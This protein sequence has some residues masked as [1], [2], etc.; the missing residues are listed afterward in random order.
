MEYLNVKLIK[1]I[2]D[3]NYKGVVEYLELGADINYSYDT[4]LKEALFYATKSNSKILKLLI[5]NGSDIHFENGYLLV[6]CS[7][8]GITDVVLSLV[9]EYKMNNREVLES[10]LQIAVENKRTDIVIFLLD[11][12]K[13]YK[14]D[15]SFLLVQSSKNKDLKTS[16]VLMKEKVDCHLIKKELLANIS[17]SGDLVLLKYIME[18]QKVWIYDLDTKK[19][20]NNLMRKKHFVVI[21]YLFDKIDNQRYIDSY[22]DGLSNKDKSAILS[23]LL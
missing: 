2:R 16:H 3:N 21:K 4:P 15:Y 11:R 6:Q 19:I 1:N 5:K 10:S 7:A 17:Q 8:K 13:K 18:D 22:L 12:L 23:Y 9:N 20:L 14:L